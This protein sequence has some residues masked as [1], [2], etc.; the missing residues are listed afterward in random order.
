MCPNIRIKGTHHESQARRRTAACG[1]SSLNHLRYGTPILT[2]PISWMDVLKSLWLQSVH[3][4]KYL[5]YRTKRRI[6]SWTT[7]APSRIPLLNHLRYCTAA[8]CWRVSNG[9]LLSARVQV[10][11][12]IVVF[13]CLRTS[14]MM[15]CCR[16]FRWLLAGPMAATSTS[17]TRPSTLIKG[18]RHESQARRL[19]ACCVPCGTSSLNHLRYGTTPLTLPISNVCVEI[20]VNCGWKS[21]PWLQATTTKKTTTTIM[22]MI[23]FYSPIFVC[24]SPSKPETENMD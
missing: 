5:N 19:T 15:W 13:A 9:D 18:R 2:L 22:M 4:S 20:D 6:P 1:T 3:F 21:F 14:W 10:P 16:S 24:D 12:G 8:G 17:S 11:L 7:G 23:P